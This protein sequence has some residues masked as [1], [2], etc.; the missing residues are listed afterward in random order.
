MKT[1][2]KFDCVRMKNEIQARIRK[3]SEG[4]S[5]EEMQRRRLDRLEHSNEP[6]AKLWRQLEK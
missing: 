2:K 3:T 4:L 1:A 6:I 5:E